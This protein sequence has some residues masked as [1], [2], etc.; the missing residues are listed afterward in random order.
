MKK[1]L[2]GLWAISVVFSGVVC[3]WAQE[4]SAK[5]AVF[6]IAH[7]DFQDDEFSL[8]LAVLSD[9]GVLVAIASSS[10]EQATG[11]NGT[12]TKPDMLLKDVRA[13]NFDAVVFI[14]GPGAAEY[15]H[16]PLALQL[17]QDSV[18]KGKVLGA[19]CLAPV[20][21]ANSGVLKGKNATVYP[22]E[23]A[24]LKAGGAV[25]SAQPVEQDGRIITADGP[26]SAKA[27]GQAL[28]RELKGGL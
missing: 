6:I 18:A 2:L 24:N 28:A 20:I 3:S 14:G 9:N 15:L 10:L 19:I 1:I 25:Y 11:T 26:K 22:T 5:T 21:L 16:D 12:T 23:A 13:D 17:A 7:K 8:P 27:F 4:P